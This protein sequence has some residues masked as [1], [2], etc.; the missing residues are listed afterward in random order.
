MVLCIN[1]SSSQLQCAPKSLGGLVKTQTLGFTPKFLFSHLF[2]V[3]KCM[4]FN[5]W[6]IATVRIPNSSVTPRNSLM[7]PLYNK[8]LTLSL[9]LATTDL[10]SVLTVLFF[11]IYVRS[12]G[13][14]PLPLAFLHSGGLRWGWRIHISGSG[15]H[16]EN[17]WSTIST[18]NIT[19]FL[20]ISSIANLISHYSPQPRV[21]LLLLA[22]SVSPKHT[23][24]FSL[25]LYASLILQDQNKSHSFLETSVTTPS[26]TVL[27]LFYYK[28]TKQRQI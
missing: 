23:I 28:I 18:S 5:T 3:Y 9:S 16:F 19:F 20:L 27:S 2:W 22:S 6:I 13:M 25:H 7:L 12:Y 10:F 14:Q 8:A 21:H 4:S 11:L 26:Q 17:R 1:H 24:F 15:P